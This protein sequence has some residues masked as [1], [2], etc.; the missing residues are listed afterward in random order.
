[1]LEKTPMAVLERKPKSGR[2]PVKL[3]HHLPIAKLSI[4]FSWVHSLSYASL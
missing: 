4:A 2:L 3:G 1:M